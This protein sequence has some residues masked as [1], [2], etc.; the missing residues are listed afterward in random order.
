MHFSCTSGTPLC[1]SDVPTPAAA[2]DGERSRW[3]WSVKGTDRDLVAEVAGR[4]IPAALVIIPGPGETVTF[5][6]QERGPYAG[7]WLL[8]G[9]KAEFGQ[10]VAAAGRRGAVEESGCDPGRTGADRSI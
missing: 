9:G 3:A 8:P 4:V 10:P 1:T 2:L 7:W 5:V 6:R